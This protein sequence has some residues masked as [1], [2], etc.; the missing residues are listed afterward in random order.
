MDWTFL[1]LTGGNS[2]TMLDGDAPERDLV[3]K[4]LLRYADNK[5]IPVLGVCRGMQ[6]MQEFEGN[7]DFIRISNHITPQQTI[8]IKQ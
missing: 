3:E 2:L 4:E 8:L 7:H 5:N 6:L 1:V